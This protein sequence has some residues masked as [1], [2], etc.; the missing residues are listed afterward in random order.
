MF[1]MFVSVS[2]IAA[3]NIHFQ[4]IRVYFKLRRNTMHMFIINILLLLQAKQVNVLVIVSFNN[5]VLTVRLC[6]V[7][8]D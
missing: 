2:I 8:W 1:F 3:V 5:P 6:D 4:F 7:E